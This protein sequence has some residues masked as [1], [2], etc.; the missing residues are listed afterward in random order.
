MLPFDPSRHRG[1]EDVTEEQIRGPEAPR[2]GQAGS[3]HQLTHPHGQTAPPEG[4]STYLEVRTARLLTYLIIYDFL[5]Y[6]GT[7]G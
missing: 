7:D 6:S 1:A 5:N 2:R 3:A 4:G